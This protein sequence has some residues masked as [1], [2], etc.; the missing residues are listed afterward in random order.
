MTMRSLRLRRGGAGAREEEEEE[1]EEDEEEEKA[2]PRALFFPSASS[3]SAGKRK[4][5]KRKTRKLRRGC[6]IGLSSHESMNISASCGRNL[7]PWRPPAVPR[8]QRCLTT[9]GRAIFVRK[10][11]LLG[12]SI[13]H[14]RLQILLL[15]L[16]IH[17]L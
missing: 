4:E 6:S 17:L 7:D 16:Q 8:E 9:Q 3:P 10:R 11:Q 2:K 13:L 5:K 12:L 1:E 14:A 15:R